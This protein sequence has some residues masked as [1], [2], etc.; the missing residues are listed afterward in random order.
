MEKITGQVQGKTLSEILGNSSVVLGVSDAQ[1]YENKISKMDL[2]DLYRHGMQDFGIKPSI[3]TN[4]KKYRKAFEAKCIAAF[5]RKTG[6]LP[7]Q[8]I[9]RKLTKKKKSEVDAILSR[10]K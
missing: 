1:S 6:S 4:G 8:S 9:E 10:I 3:T 7:D 5:K 2:E